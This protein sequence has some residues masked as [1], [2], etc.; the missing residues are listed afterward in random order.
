MTAAVNQYIAEFLRDAQYR[1]GELTQQMIELRDEGSFRYE[2]LYNQ[3]KALWHFFKIVY[4]NYTDFEESG[5][6]FLRCSHSTAY[7]E[8]TD[9]EI[10]AEIDY[11]RAFARMATLPYLAFTGYYPE[12]VGTILGDGF[13][14]GGD[15]WTP[16]EGDYLEVLRYD[17]S[18]NLVPVPWP[19]YAGMRSM[20]ID[21]YFAGRT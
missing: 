7:P 17:V 5:Y 14:F 18:G 16:P 10:I 15:G 1:V 12:I 11:L 9:R 21:D 3:R 8:W 4:D 6:N 13:N 19:D 2:E 20:T